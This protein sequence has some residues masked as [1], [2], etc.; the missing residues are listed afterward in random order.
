MPIA[1]TGGLPAN[2]TPPDPEHSRFD[3][4]G[5][6]AKIHAVDLSPCAA[7]ARGAI[8]TYGHARLRFESGGNVS[9][10]LVDGPAGLSDVTASCIGERLGAVAVHPFEG[11]AVTVGASYFVP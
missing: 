8:K 5:A 10:V 9:Q 7:T 4:T 6:L 2:V 3:G 1:T 11:G